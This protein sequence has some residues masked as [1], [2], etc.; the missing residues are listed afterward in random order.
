LSSTN[1]LWDSF[2]A[3]HAT[4]DN[5]FHILLWRIRFLFTSKYAQHLARYSP[6]LKD[7]RLLEVGCGS[8]RTLHYLEQRNPGS[9]CYAWDLSPQAIKV[10]RKLSPNFHA[11][12]ASAFDLPLSGDAVDVS[13][14][15]GLIEH[16]TRK[17]AAQMVSEKIRVTRPGGTVGIVV[18]W[19]NSIYNLVI[20]RAFGKHWPF[21]NE[22]PFRRGELTEFM[23]NLGL[24]DIKIHVIYGSALLGIGRKSK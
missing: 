2:W 6:G 21:G 7:A 1:G 23:D 3:T 4:K 11:G 14:S 13:F 9:L 8:A 20:R 12:V 18:P 22:F 10:L 19:Q 5:L 15:I 17:E 24:S 16:F